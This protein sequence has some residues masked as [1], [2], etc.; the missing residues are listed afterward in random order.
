VDYTASVNAAADLQGGSIANQMRLVANYPTFIW[1]DTI[2]AVHGTGGYARSLESHM[3]LALTQPGVNAIGI[4]VYDLPNRDCSALASNGELL[5]AND[6][7]NIY[8]TQYIDEIYN[9]ISQSKYSNLRIIM[10]IEPDS[11]PNLITNLS[12]AKCQE[13]QSTGA[14]V[15]CS[16]C[17]R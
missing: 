14:Y 17:H 9:V 13:A 6:G 15:R 2:D 16:I 5:I 10:V 12:F 8:K 7:L 3:D 4:V 11:L 1:M